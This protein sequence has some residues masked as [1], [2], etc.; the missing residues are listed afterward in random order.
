[1]FI[2]LEHLS[3]V[4]FRCC[5]ERSDNHNIRQQVP[6]FVISFVDFRASQFLWKNRKTVKL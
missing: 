3:Y 5:S 6:N 2:I 4:C 1:M